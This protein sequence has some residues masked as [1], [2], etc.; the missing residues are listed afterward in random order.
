MKDTII[1]YQISRIEV[2]KC[3]TQR[4]AYDLR[5]ESN[6]PLVWSGMNRVI[7]SLFGY[8]HDD[9]ELFMIPEFRQYIA[10]AHEQNPCWIY[11]SHLESNWLKHIAL[12]LVKNGVAVTNMKKKISD[13]IFLETEVSEFIQGQLEQFFT[14][15]EMTSVPLEDAE[16]RVQ[17][18]FKSF[19]D[20]PQE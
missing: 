18:V 17:A 9:R 3:I 15:C 2:E 13:I 6:N 11:F 14:L 16:N 19:K 4:I 12:C 10:K 8:D 20:A 7:F 5:A 1:T